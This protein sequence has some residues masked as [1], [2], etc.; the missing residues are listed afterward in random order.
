MGSSDLVQSHVS[1]GVEKNPMGLWCRLFKCTPYGGALVASRVAMATSSRY[2][3]E[4]LRNAIEKGQAQDSI[5]V[6]NISGGR[7]K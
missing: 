7:G 1:C 4:A 5:G 6:G 3:T 2:G